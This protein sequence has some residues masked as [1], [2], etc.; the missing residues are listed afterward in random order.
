MSGRY[1]RTLDHKSIRAHLEHKRLWHRCGTATFAPQ[2]R[3]TK[4]A[5]RPHSSIAFLFSSAHQ[6]ARFHLPPTL[7]SWF[8]Q[9]S[10]RVA[11]ASSMTS[12][13]HPGGKPVSVSPDNSSSVKIVSEGLRPPS[14]E[15]C[16]SSSLPEEEGSRPKCRRRASS[17]S[18]SNSEEGEEE[19]EAPP[20]P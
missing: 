2:P 16:T 12:S 6:P 20:C 14:S 15:E 9:T 7:T 17:T 13:S 1:W 4:V 3:T 18:R 11:Y 19:R 5:L 10:S 8:R